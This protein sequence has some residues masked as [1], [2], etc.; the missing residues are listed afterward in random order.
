MTEK[1]T[2]DSKQWVLFGRQRPVALSSPVEGGGKSTLDKSALCRLA[3]RGRRVARILPQLLDEVRADGLLRPLLRVANRLRR[4]SL[5]DSFFLTLQAPANHVG[6][7]V[8]RLLPK[9]SDPAPGRT[10]PAVSPCCLGRLR[11]AEGRG[12]L[13]AFAFP[14]GI[15][16]VFSSQRSHPHPGLPSHPPTPPPLLTVMHLLIS[17]GG[18]GLAQL[19]TGRPLVAFTSNTLLPTYALG[20]LTVFYVPLVFT[21]MRTF[22]PLVEPALELVDACSRVRALTL[23]LADFTRTQTMRGAPAPGLFPQLLVGWISI[24]GGGILYK[25][26]AGIATF[27]YP[28]WD[29]TAVGVAVA[30]LVV[31]TDPVF[32]ALA[33]EQAAPILPYSKMLG[34]PVVW[35]ADDFRVVCTLVIFFGFMTRP[36]RAVAKVMAGKRTAVVA[37]K[38]KG[39]K[40]DVS[41]K[42]EVKVRK[43]SRK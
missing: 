37:P 6:S 36:A 20:Y 17:L 16:Y 2:T 38:E 25:W 43:S 4:Y 12:W 14:Q 28:G 13:E 10:D 29:F 15:M 3:L 40:G 35:G 39:E 9:S 22:S 19:L 18:G 27:E 23:G 42:G 33:A 30:A 41:D 26:S 1:G 34:V 21:L 32:G 7:S 8:N 24:T 11:H 5:R 31:G